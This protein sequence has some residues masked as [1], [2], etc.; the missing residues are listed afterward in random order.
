AW[1][2]MGLIYTDLVR[3]KEALQCYDKTLKLNPKHVGALLNKGVILE[4]AGLKKEAFM[5]FQKAANLDTKIAAS[6]KGRLAH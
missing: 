2:H 4:D 6:I 5:C 3:H 1:Y